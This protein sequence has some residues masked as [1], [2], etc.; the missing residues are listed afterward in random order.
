MRFE[1]GVNREPWTRKEVFAMRRALV[2][3]VLLIVVA[4]TASAFVL[5]VTDPAVT[6]RNSITAGIKQALVELQ[7]AQRR[8][9]RRMARR[10]SMFSSLEK[11]AVADPPRWRTRRPGEFLYD[12]E[13]NAALTFGD[14]SGMVYLEVTEP[15]LT[16]QQLLS[17]RSS[18]ARAAMR[19]RLATVD[20]ADAAAIAATN[21]TGELRFNGRKY[22]L[23]A[24]DALETTVIDPS[25]EQS[26][27][28]VLDKI[29]A[30]VLVGA[31]QR[32]ART[33]LLTG[34]VEQLLVDS[35]RARD[36]EAATINMQLVTWRDGRAANEA[37]AA[38]TGD[39]LRA[40]RQP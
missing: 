18:I 4:E 9:L 8:Q 33:Q 14:P 11:Y 31:R 5:I 29:S 13:Y 39:A 7:Q 6:L 19:A 23:Q 37:F 22:E 12:G 10:L 35:K 1:H 34:I 3:A 21:D 16:A 30:A 20:A 36:T 40:W 32:Q 28:A 26:A 15:I 25:D 38:G 17:V 27:T 24:I 2:L